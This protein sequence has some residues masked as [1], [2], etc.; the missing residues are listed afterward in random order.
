MATIEKDTR[1]R[2]VITLDKI[3][4]ECCNDIHAGLERYEQFLQWGQEC[5]SEYMM[6]TARQLTVVELP[7]TAWKA[8]EWPVDLVGAPVLVGVRHKG[9]LI[10][11]TNDQDI[12][13][14]HDVEDGER[15]ANTV[16][17]FSDEDLE[18]VSDRIVRFVNQNSHGEDLGGLFGFLAKDNGVGYFR[19]DR[20][21]R[22]TQLNPIIDNQIILMEYVAAG[23]KPC[24][25]TIVPL[26]AKKMHK[27][28]IHWQRMYF[29][30]S[31][32]QAEKREAE[33][34]FGIALRET[35]ERLD[36]T[37]IADIAEAAIDGYSGSPHF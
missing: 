29:S 21:R 23:H 9:K 28:Y 22:E 6:D 37:T 34:L 31:Y 20:K 24:S 15:V 16:E 26:E 19:H 36:D 2:G 8:V 10:V 14:F 11:F 3:V 5:H 17:S 32:N 25:A 4:R 30:K 7:M 27:R 33:R 12:P 13:L 1:Q 35:T 18:I